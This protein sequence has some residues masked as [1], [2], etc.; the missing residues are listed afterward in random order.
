MGEV[1]ERV[2]NQRVIAHTL[3]PA[4]DPLKIGSSTEMPT[5]TDTVTKQLCGAAG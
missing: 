3:K 1:K 4:L 2:G 5:N